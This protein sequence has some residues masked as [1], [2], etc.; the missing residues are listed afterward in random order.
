MKFTFD[1]PVTEGDTFGVTPSVR[2]PRC[3]GVYGV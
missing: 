2:K 3:I 1:T